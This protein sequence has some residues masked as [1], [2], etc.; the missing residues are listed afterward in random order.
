MDDD[1]ADAE[2]HTQRVTTP[3]DRSSAL[4]V[5]D[6]AV[7]PLPSSPPPAPFGTNQKGESCALDV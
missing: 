3:S 4:F 6:I 5:A 7:P 2:R 1:P